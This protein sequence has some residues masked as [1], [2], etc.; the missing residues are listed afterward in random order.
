MQRSRVESL[1]A[2]RY[3]WRPV[4]QSASV[5]VLLVLLLSSPGYAH[6][7]DWLVRVNELRAVGALPPVI[8]NPTWSQGCWLHSRYMAENYYIGH[9]EDAG[10]RWYSSEGAAAA[11]SS[12][13]FLGVGGVDAID[14]WMQT[15]F[16]GIGMIDPRLGSVGFGSYTSAS[17]VPAATLD[18]IRGWGTQPIPASYPVYWP[19]NG[20]TIPFRSYWGGEYPDPLSNSGYTTPV[21]PP[22]FLQIGSGSAVPVVSSSSFRS[23]TTVLE[24]IVVTETNYR[25]SDS[26]AQSLGRA[27]LDGRDA[28]VLVPRAPLALGTRYDVEVICNGA[29]YAWWF[30]TPEPPADTALTVLTPSTTL[31]KYGDSHTIIGRLESDGVALSGKRVVLQTSSTTSG[32]RDSARSAVTAADGGFSFGVTPRRRTYYRVRFAGDASYQSAASAYRRVTPRALVGTPKAPQTMYAGRAKTVYGYLKPRHTAGS[33]PVRIYKYRRV[34]GRW[35]S[36]GYV[37][38][39][40]YNYSTYTKYSA[41]MRLPYRGNWRLRAYHPADGGHPAQWSAKYRYVAVR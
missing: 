21:G 4:V 22:I 25:N 7:S 20:Q 15:P 34:A 24:H 40:A 14:G 38:A 8:E 23:G 33:R 13:C 41:S 6:A 30:V 31:A 27:V 37:N 3:R 36:Y 9:S 19:A 12:N 32:F 39:R 1:R 16:H 2:T 11:A 29:T 10:N 5:F 28:V 18:V 26:A 17:G 35:K